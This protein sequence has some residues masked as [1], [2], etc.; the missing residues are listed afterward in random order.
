MGDELKGR[1][2][3]L[4]VGGRPLTPSSTDGNGAT[5]SEIAE[6]GS[7]LGLSHGHQDLA[8]TQMLSPDD[9]KSLELEV[10]DITDEL[11][12]ASVSQPSFRD[13]SN[14]IKGG[15]QVESDSP[16]ETE[17]SA[18]I[19]HEKAT[20]PAN[21][22]AGHVGDDGVREGPIPE[23][24]GG[25][26]DGEPPVKR[27]RTDEEG[28]DK[29]IS[30]SIAEMNHLESI[31]KQRELTEFEG[32]AYKDLLARS[33][34]GGKKEGSDLKPEIMK[35]E[36]QKQPSFKKAP[37]KPANKVSTVH[38]AKEFWAKFDEEEKAGGRKRKFNMG[39]TIAEMVENSNS[40][41]ARAARGD[42]QLAVVTEATN[43]RRDE[44]IKRMSAPGAKRGDA[45]TLNFA[46][47][48]FGKGN[49]E[50]D[51]VA[52][53]WKVAGIAWSLY[54]HQVVGVGE[55]LRKELSQGGKKG[56]I[57]GDEPGL[58]KTVQIAAICIC[59]PPTKAEKARKR[60]TTL[61]VC[62]ASSIN[63]FMAELNSILPKQE[64]KASGFDTSS[65]SD[66]ERYEDEN[67]VGRVMQYKY[68]TSKETGQIWKKADYL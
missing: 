55:G 17:A 11:T 15:D 37:Q 21:G 54:P 58:G 52:F 9:Q 44:A 34:R 59:N 28:S 13:D 38:S 30:M 47:Q 56:G 8:D 41:E 26:S 16:M 14:G 22:G 33:G 31:R 1:E 12:A 3:D 60:H 19:K 50:P 20:P 65:A 10:I 46:L 48:S 63:Q 25:P 5:A 49:T 39:V 62:P 45:A 36:E 23:D 61:I 29:K 40:M 67:G 24:D 7:A 35:E 43:K 64:E 2:A 32:W 53:K 68:K 4:G 6:V 57:L 66:D 27:Q 42:V 51:P 18:S